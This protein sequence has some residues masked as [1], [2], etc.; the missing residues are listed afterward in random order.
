MRRIASV[1]DGSDTD[2][3]HTTDVS[4]TIRELFWKLVQSFE[5][6]IRP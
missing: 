5:T 3:R 1:I 6:G 4:K 2:R